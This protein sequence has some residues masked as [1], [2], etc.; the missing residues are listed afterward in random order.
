MFYIYDC[1]HILPF[2]TFT[3]VFAFNMIVMYS[4][5]LDLTGKLLEYQRE[6]EI[7]TSLENSNSI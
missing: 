7:E 5:P 4:F 3:C 6:K 1:L 2:I